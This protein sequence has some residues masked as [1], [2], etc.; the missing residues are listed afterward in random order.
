VQFF[1]SFIPSFV[2]ILV[3]ASSLS[4][5]PSS[6]SSLLLLHFYFL[7]NKLFFLVVFSFKTFIKHRCVAE[8]LTCAAIL[9]VEPIFLAPSSS[10][11]VTAAASGG[12]GGAEGSEDDDEKSI[13]PLA[14]ARAQAAMAH[15]GLTVR[16]EEDNVKNNLRIRVCVCVFFF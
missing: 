11:A 6:P 8:I 5:S 3:G 7:S 16:Y 1:P 2:V 13:D 9:S 15:R 4:P 14:E 12:G 10:D